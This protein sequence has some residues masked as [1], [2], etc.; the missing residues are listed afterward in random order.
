ML[1]QTENAGPTETYGGREPHQ[2]RMRSHLSYLRVSASAR[3]DVYKAD[4]LKVRFQIDGQNLTIMD[5][6]DF[7]DLFLGNAIGP[8]RGVALRLTTDF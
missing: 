6:I 8:S 4:R 5:V 7:G 1:G 3:A 2:L